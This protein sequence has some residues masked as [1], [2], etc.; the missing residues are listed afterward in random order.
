MACSPNFSVV[1]LPCYGINNVATYMWGINFAD[2]NP[3]GGKIRLP[4]C[5]TT[6]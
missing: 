4:K 2:L 1:V 6:H 3:L 5:I